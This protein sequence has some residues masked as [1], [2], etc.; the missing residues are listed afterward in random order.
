MTLRHAGVDEDAEVAVL[1][2][3]AEG[4]ASRRAIPEGHLPT[5]DG[6]TSSVAAAGISAIVLVKIN[7]G[8]G[9]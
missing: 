7:C 2:E 9:R 8:T 6:S 4:E 3:S 1:T 5:I